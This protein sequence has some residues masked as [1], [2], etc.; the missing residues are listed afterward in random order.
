[1]KNTVFIVM[2]ILVSGVFALA[3]NSNSVE[4]IEREIRRL[5]TA[6]A[7]AVLR[8][9]FAALDRLCAEDFIV[10]SPRNNIVKGRDGVKELIRQ[11]V[12]DYA[13]FTREIETVSIY[14]KTAI[15]MGRET[16]VTKA[17]AGQTEQNQSRRYTNIWI[18][19]GGKWLLTARHA[20]II[21]P[22]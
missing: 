6:Q 8:K 4:A 1:M 13:S 3:Q 18:K 15:V 20:S 21:Y 22:D 2:F 7:E 19:K 12:I 5:D 9:D 11:G 16:I 14:E 10:N 17:G